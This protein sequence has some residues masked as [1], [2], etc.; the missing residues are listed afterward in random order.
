MVTVIRKIFTLFTK[1]ERRQAYLLLMPMT[2]SAII[3]VIGIAFVVP[4]M[5]LVSDPS[6]IEHHEKLAYVYNLFHFQSTHLFLIFLGILVLLVLFCANSFAALTTWLMLR[7]TANRGATVSHRLLKKYLQQ[8]YVFFLNQNS[9]NLGKNILSEVSVVVYTVFIPCL[10]MLSKIV[11]MV[12]IMLLLFIVNPLLAL[13][14]IVILGG[15]YLLIFWFARKK[16]FNISQ[17]LVVDQEK[18]FKI[19]NEIFGGIKDVKLLRN[20]GFFLEE[21]MQASIRQANSSAM[22]QVISLLPRY[23]LETIAFGGILLIVLIMLA[24]N[25]NTA[26]IIPMLALYAFA[27]YRLM[28]GLQM[29]FWAMT[30][31]K[32]NSGSLDVLYNDFKGLKIPIDVA[33]NMEVLPIRFNESME[34]KHLGFTYPNVDSSVINDLNLKIDANTTIGFVGS[35][36]SGKTTTVDLMLG[37]LMP[38]KG[39]LVV[40]GVVIDDSNVSSW[41]SNLGYVPQHIFLSDDTIANNIAFGVHREKINAKLVEEAAKIANL[42]DFVVNELPNGYDTV[43]GERGIRLSGGQRQRIGI[44]RALYC[45]PGVL[46]M[47]E[48]TSSLD[49]ITETAVMDAIHNLAHKKTIIIIAHRLTTVKECDVIYVMEDGGIVEKGNYDNLIKNSKRF[50]KMAK[51]SNREI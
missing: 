42:H 8:P 4:F 40:D 27:G 50:R 13:I 24:V 15:V 49:G 2:I 26:Q 9:A 28:P 23:A 34:L 38:Q 25:H 21:F 51:T 36:G 31:I 19:V 22:N 11:G 37:L 6:A 14:V 16:L 3:D 43:I 18:R 39:Q 48:A 46:I 12:F 30:T 44:A 5:M 7:F 17:H 47:D 33:R 10:Q 41:Q 45:D 32:A 20:E 35:T 1:R 29:I